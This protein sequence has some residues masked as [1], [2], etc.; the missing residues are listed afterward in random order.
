M[1][2]NKNGFVLVELLIIIAVIAALGFIGYK[3]V[4]KSSERK[5]GT[6][7][8]GTSNRGDVVWAYDEGQKQWITESGKAPACQEPFKLDQTP[9]DMT[10]VNSVLMPGSYRGYNYKPHGGFGVNEATQGKVEVKMPMDATLVGLKRYYEGKP[11]PD[12][13]YLLTFESDCGI[14]FRFDHLQTLT[15]ELQAL[16]EKTPEPKLDD[17]RSSP[18]DAPPRTKFK[19]GQVIATQVGLPSSKLYGFDFGVYDYRKP[20]EISK[21]AEWAA[22]HNQHTSLEWFGV[23]WFDMLSG[24]DVDKAKTLSLQ[25]RDTRRTVKITSDYCPNAPYK[26]LDVN[27]GKPTD[28]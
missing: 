10:Q 21:N 19:A 16:A 7:P 20:N 17:S 8:N 15:P 26:T 2:H 23:C 11:T 25:Q 22:I 28:G 4:S 5:S 1:K 24:S 27:N 9:V 3:F 14:A 18:D 6:S 12:L 13:Q